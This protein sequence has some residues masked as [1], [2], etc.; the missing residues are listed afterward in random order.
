MEAYNILT[1]LVV[2]AAIFGNINHRY[3]RIPGSVGIMLL[4]LLA[5][6]LIVAAGAVL[7]KFF[8]HI[9]EVIS[10]ID[11][12][13]VVMNVM[14]SF[15]LFAAGIQVDIKKMRRERAAIIAAGSLTSTSVRTDFD[16]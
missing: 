7:P 15:L 14:L 6:L 4:S 9:N 1:I 12:H 16:G 2:L 11:F 13:M 8:I 5:S 3:I 10:N